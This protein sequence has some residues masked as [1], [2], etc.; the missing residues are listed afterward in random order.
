M[1]DA[2]GI[3]IVFLTAAYAIN[4]LAGL[5]KGERILI[6]AAAGGVGL[7]AVQLA[8]QIGA[9]I[10]ATA[11]HEEKR[12]YLRSLGVEHVM[13]SRS[14]DFVDAVKELTNG[15]GIDVVLNSLAGEFIP[16]GLGLLRYRGRFLEI[17]KRDIIYGFKDRPFAFPKQ[18]FLPR[19]RSLSDDRAMRPVAGRLCSIC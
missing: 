11:G 8:Q 16:A 17:G 5:K 10:F 2:A 15:E 12:E 14:L 13:D 6:H 7:A 3:P 9:E 19:D 1:E 4:T 18:S